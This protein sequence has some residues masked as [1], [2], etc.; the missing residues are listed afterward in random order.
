MLVQPERPADGA[1][2]AG[3]R[4]SRRPHPRRAGHG[5]DGRHRLVGF[6]RVLPAAGADG[7]GRR[8]Q[9]RRVRPAGVH[10]RRRVRQPRRPHVPLPG[11]AAAG[12]E[13][14]LPA[15]TSSISGRPSRR[16]WRP[17]SPARKRRCAGSRRSWWW[18]AASRT[19]HG[20]PAGGF[21]W[22]GFRP[23]R[24]DRVAGSPVPAAGLLR[25][26]ERRQRGSR[27]GRPVEC[28]APL[29][30]PPRAALRRPEAAGPGRGRAAP[31]QPSRRPGPGRGRS[32]SG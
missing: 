25:R 27:A 9:R 32:D 23:R 8:R 30:V 12:G 24:R 29:P 7:R 28:L 10:R 2:A 26:L 11:T 16:C 1:P 6:P 18:L 5:G 20:S 14:P 22:C 17:A 13:P 15:T 19:C 31:R 3:R 4:G 21:E